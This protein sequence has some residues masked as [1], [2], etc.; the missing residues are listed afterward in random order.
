[1]A[2]CAES[3][4]SSRERIWKSAC[5][6]CPGV[7]AWTVSWK[8]KFVVLIFDIWAQFNTTHS[9]E[10]GFSCFAR[11]K[12]AEASRCHLSW[13][14]W[15]SWH[16]TKTYVIH[17]WYWIQWKWKLLLPAWCTTWQWFSNRELVPP[18]GRFHAISSGCSTECC[19]TCCM[20]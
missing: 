10:V 12:S 8:S 2:P 6:Q 5:V 7:N 20:K 16:Y 15:P 1:M 13:Y 11:T 19:E 17:I 4:Q 9:C 18:V 14:I 3:N